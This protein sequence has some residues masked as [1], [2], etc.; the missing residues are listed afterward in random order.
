MRHCGSSASMRPSK[1]LSI[2]SLQGP[3]WIDPSFSSVVAIPSQIESVESVHPSPSLSIPSLHCVDG[4]FR[5][6][7]LQSRTGSSDRPDH[8]LVVNPF[9]TSP[10]PSHFVWV[11]RVNRSDRRGPSNRHHRCHFIITSWCMCFIISK[12][13]S[14]GSSESVS[15]RIIIDEVVA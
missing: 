6:Y 1:S 2:P 11:K 4:S 15:R 9:N 14:S 3:P 13:E 12:A 8:P 5:R 7:L 10:Y